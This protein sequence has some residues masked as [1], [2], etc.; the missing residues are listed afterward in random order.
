MKIGINLLEKYESI[1][2]IESIIKNCHGVIYVWTNNINGKQYVGQCLTSRIEA[3]EREHEKAND[4]CRELNA[5]IIKYGS[6]NFSREIIDVAYSSNEL[7]LLETLYISM[8]ESMYP[9]GYN[10][11]PGGKY[12]RNNGDRVKAE[13]KDEQRLA[14]RIEKQRK[15]RELMNYGGNFIPIDTVEKL[16]NDLKVLLD[17]GIITTAAYRDAQYLYR[18]MLEWKICVDETFEYGITEYSE[19]IMME[20]TGIGE[21][22]LRRCKNILLELGY[23][24]KFEASKPRTPHVYVANLLVQ[25]N[26]EKLSYILMNAKSKA[27]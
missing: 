21:T 13:V 22:T 10:L 26:E 5:D 17:A 24:E 14:E 8:Y 23:I 16:R 20:F 27:I 19:E 18:C 4:G 12:I 15:D 2:E 1:D 7:D 3:R 25:D 6:L 11:S 9:N